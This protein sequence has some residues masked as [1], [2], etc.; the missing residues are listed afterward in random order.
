MPLR[1][2]LAVNLLF[3]ASACSDPFQ[4]ASTL[5]DAEPTPNESDATDAPS[6]PDAPPSIEGGLSDA[7]DASLSPPVA[8]DLL[9]W[10]RAD[11]GVIET[12]G[13]VSS[14]A[15]QSGHHS[16]AVQTDA[17]KQPKLGSRGSGTRPAVVF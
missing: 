11:A 1:R 8:A 16:D 4:A 9:L 12:R 5:A 15:D 13:L 14:W 3:A 2:L 6:Q 10:L 7:S 17:T